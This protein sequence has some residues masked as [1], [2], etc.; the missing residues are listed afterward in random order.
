MA[1]I[2]ETI[3]L[4]VPLAVAREKWNEYLNGMIIGSGAA[5]REREYPIRWRKE[6]RDAAQ[7]AVQFATM[8]EVRTR[9][10][11]TLEYPQDRDDPEPGKD[12]IERLRSELRDDLDLFRRYAEGKL[13]KAS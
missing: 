13:R 3:D 8:D 7:G 10:T 9:L 4:H 2:G 12:E 1:T 5:P 6:E 11:I